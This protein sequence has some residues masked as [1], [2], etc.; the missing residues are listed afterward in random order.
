MRG[1]TVPFFM[2]GY[3]KALPPLEGK[4]FEGGARELRPVEFPPGCEASDKGPATE[5]V[6]AERKTEQVSF[7]NSW[8]F[9]L[10]SSARTTSP[11]LQERPRQAARRLKNLEKCEKLLENVPVE[12]DSEVRKTCFFSLLFLFIKDLSLWYLCLLCH[13]LSV[14]LR[15][16]TDKFG[17]LLRGVLLV[18]PCV[19]KTA[20]C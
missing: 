4:G 15:P 5:F 20:V 19:I 3:K 9:E 17:G 11:F 12:G 1:E 6:D 10:S 2:K 8:C 18:S 14:L 16:L 13:G 7:S